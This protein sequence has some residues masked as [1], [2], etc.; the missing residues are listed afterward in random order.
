[1]IQFGWQLYAPAPSPA[2]FFHKMKTQ[3]NSANA[4]RA[5]FQSRSTLSFS[6]AF[7]REFVQQAWKECEN[8]RHS[9]HREIT[10][11]HNN[12]IMMKEYGQDAPHCERFPS[13]EI[14]I[15]VRC[16]NQQVYFYHTFIG[17]DLRC[18]MILDFINYRIKYIKYF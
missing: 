16:N 9:D 1:M 5:I 7:G 8:R 2:E 10:E 18:K 14:I 12:T 15:S 13:D 3:K 4:G 6:I 17:C 11:I